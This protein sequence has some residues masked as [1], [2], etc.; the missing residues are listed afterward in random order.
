MAR[1]RVEGLGMGMGLISYG[2]LCPRALDSV[3]ESLRTT[4][5][6]SS[7]RTRP[8]AAPFVLFFLRAL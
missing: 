5:T 3:C 2:V 7:A 6:H 1:F 4:T 8:L